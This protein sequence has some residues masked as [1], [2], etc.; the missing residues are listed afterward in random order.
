[1][2]PRL[3]IIGATGFV[4]SRWA[5][6]ASAAFEVIR[7]ARSLPVS[8]TSV[9]ID[10]ADEASVQAAFDRARPDFV[11]LLAALSDVD[12]CEREQEL[13]ERIN[14]AGAVHVARHCGRTGAR[15]LYSSTDAVFEGTGRQY[16]EE[17]PMSPVNWYGH[18]KARAE[19]EIARIVPTATI[20]RFSL[21]LGG[22]ALPGGNSY[23]QKV[24][25]NL[26]A[27]NQIISPTYEYRNPIDV[28]TLCEF[29][30][31]LTENL[32]ATGI[33]HIGATDKISRFDLASC[34]ARELGGDPALI[35]PQTAPVP[36]RAP[37]GHDD[38]L[39]TDRLR[40]LCRTPIPNC[41]EVIKRAVATLPS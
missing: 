36:G 39:V 37:R 17:D 32:A 2:V 19:R 15:L 10:I 6:R 12:R 28:N 35:V 24:A 7:G 33:V 13:A 3:L 9:T 30:L 5:T 1:M 41:Q 27:G 14:V 34:I 26:R 25:G 16:S 38:F 40:Q 29:L 11:T 18:T 20:V 8:A 4:G 21:V 31:E 23:M 22:S